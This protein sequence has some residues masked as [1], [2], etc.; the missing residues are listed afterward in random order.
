M[1]MKNLLNIGNSVSLF[2]IF[3]LFVSVV[4]IFSFDKNEVVPYMNPGDIPKIELNNFTIY[5]IDKD[6]LLTKLHARN[7]KQFEKFEEFSDVVLER[8]NNN[9]IDRLTTSN[10]IKKDNAIFFDEGV[11]NNRDGYDMYSTRAVYFI[12]RNTLEGSGFFRI[13]GNFQDIKGD[14]VYYD[15]KTGVV[16]AK[17]IQAKLNITKAKK[18]S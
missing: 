3:L 4:V 1:R 5:Q 16:F 15:G 8:L 13:N 18:K 12:D 14:D 6:N 17:N 2:F 7:A 11:N 9:I 10:A